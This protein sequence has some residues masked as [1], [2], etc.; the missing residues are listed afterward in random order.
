MVPVEAV[1]LGDPVTLRAVIG[2]G[3]AVVFSWWFT[4]K[5]NGT[6][7][8]GVKTV[9][10]LNSGCLNNSVVSRGNS[11]YAHVQYIKINGFH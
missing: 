10:P 7:M 9:C 4:H 2:G 11:C 8:E 6:N 3:L 1:Y 5:E